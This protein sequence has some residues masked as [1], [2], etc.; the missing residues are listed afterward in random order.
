[1]RTVRPSRD[2]T[3]VAPVLV[4][5][6]ITSL[7]VG[8]AV[9]KGAYDHV[10]PTALAGMRLTFSAMIMWVLV[11]PRLRQITARQ[12]RAVISLGIVF[13]AM[14]M[15]YFQAISHLQ[16]GVAAT[17]E[18]LG[19]LMLSIVLS[20]RLEHLAAALLA[21]TGVLLL[22]TSGASLSPLGILLGVLAA[23][24]RA[25]YVVL[26]QQVGRL[27]PDWS[28]LAVA[29]AVGA[30]ILAP[31][32]AVTDAGAIAEHPAVLETGLGVALLSSLIPYS[33]DMAVLRRIDTR[34]FG[35]L[36]ALSPA[37][38]AGVG[39]AVLHEHLAVRQAC[40]IALVV[41]ASAWSV[42]RSPHTAPIPSPAPTSADD[43][44]PIKDTEHQAQ[45]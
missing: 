38:G 18:L 42:S 37:V 39:F 27:F 9:A 8:S 22:T 17:L 2:G 41:L 29:L 6:Q 43:D 20:H 32:A 28:G 24:C 13:A 34:A 40:A 45:A 19:P 14:N 21:L 16:I 26:N 31:V 3:A 15:A 11:R 25:G 33:L 12:W 35:V 1:M 44:Q 30:C 36:L 23:L 7:Q 10:S 4:L 5:T